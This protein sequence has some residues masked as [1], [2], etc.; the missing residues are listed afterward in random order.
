MIKKFRSTDILH[1]LRWLLCRYPISSLIQ[2]FQSLGTAGLMS[3]PVNFMRP[4]Q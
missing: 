4:S 1:G 2:R 3:L